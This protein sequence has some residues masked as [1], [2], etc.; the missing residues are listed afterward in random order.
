MNLQN[1]LT[2]RVDDISNIPSLKYINLFNEVDSWKLHE[3][4][5]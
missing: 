5:T 4:N 2:D 3:L 1:Y